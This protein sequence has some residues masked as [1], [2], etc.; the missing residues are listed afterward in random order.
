[1]TRVVLA[2]LWAAVML[3]TG[4]LVIHGDGRASARG[5]EAR[6]QR[7]GETALFEAGLGEWAS[8]RISGQRATVTGQAPRKEERAAARAAVRR[9]AGPGGVLFGGV[10]RV[11]DATTLAD[12]MSPYVWQAS[13]EASGVILSGGAP[14]R[15]ARRELAQYAQQL[16]PSGLVDHMRVARGAPDDMAWAAATRAALAQLAQMTE[17]QV[18]ITDLSI[19]VTG[20][21]PDQAARERVTEA[22]SRAPAVFTTH[23]AV[24][25]LDGSEIDVEPATESGPPVITRR[26]DCVDAL[27]AAAAEGVL[28]F[29]GDG[30]ALDKESYPTL[31]AVA[32]VAKRCRGMRV[33]VLGVQREADDDATAEVED[34]VDDDPDD[35][36]KTAD[37]GVS[38]EMARARA[39]AVAD[40]LVLK[41]VAPDQSFAD[42]LV[43]FAQDASDVAVDG[44]APPVVFRVRD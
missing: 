31:D 32:A 37:A 43:D 5:V 33:V 27:A 20:R 23:F 6:L 16:F 8:V 9:A 41:G 40:Y 29:G 17:G 4:W 10:T 3:V 25:A 34:D 13:R 28:R 12:A 22:A 1:M 11:R 2:A 14:S 38:S 21:V 42:V 18:V 35:D 39:Q 24:D 36:A 26:S 15:P 30:A 19:E 44:R 7:A